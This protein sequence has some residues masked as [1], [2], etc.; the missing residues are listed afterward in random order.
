MIYMGKPSFMNLDLKTPLSNHFGL[1]SFREPQELIIRSILSKHDTMVI[2]PTGGG[3]SLCFQLPALLLPGVTIVISPLIAL[4]KDQVDGLRAQGIAAGMINSLLS[5]Q[6]QR[7]QIQLMALGKLKLVYIAPERF[8]S[9]SFIDALSRCEIS[10][11]AV[12]EAHCLSQW[13]HDFRPD[14]LRINQAL[15]YLRNPPVAAFTATATPDVRNDIVTHLCMTNP[16]IF[17]AGFARPNLALRIVQVSG[18]KEKYKRLKTLIREHK[19]G[20]IYCATRKSVERVADRLGTEG[21]P[22]TMYHGGMK[23]SERDYAQNAFIGG[24]SNVVVATNAFGMGID[25]TDIRFVAHFEMPGSVEAYYQEAG[26]AGRDGKSSVSELLFSFADKRVHDFFLEGRNPGKDLIQDVY[27]RLKTLSDERHEVVVSIDDLSSG[28]DSSVNPMAVGTALTILSRRD[29][30]QRFDVSG[31]LKRGTRLLKPHLLPEGLEFDVEAL[32]E[33]AKRDQGRLKSVID[34]A[35]AKTCR[36]SWILDYFGEGQSE[37]CR[38]C[39]RCVGTDDEVLRSPTDE[40]MLIVRKALSGVARMSYRCPGSANWRPRFGRDRILQSLIGGD[41]TYFKENG[42]ET[43]ST[44]GILK[45]E[46]K[47]YVKELLRAMERAGLLEVTAGEYPLTGLTPFGTEVMKGK[48]EFVM[49]WPHQKGSKKT[50]KKQSRPPEPSQ[51]IA[52]T[53][54]DDLYRKLNDKRASLATIRKVPP[55]VIFSNAVLEA[56]AIKKPATVEESREISGIGDK[57]AK[58]LLPTFLKIIQGHVGETL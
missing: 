25:R 21:V 57:K 27:A 20:I 36:Q 32:A 44:Y 55:Y 50:K 52:G 48:S 14:Y 35:Y 10:L 11:L 18:A 8:R 15:K 54:D 42:L 49:V 4:M 39:D 28:M 9:G 45:S 7:E 29:Y 22:L 26:R 1:E 51:S 34:F 31:T 12:D 33:K 19:I 37:Y 16:K 6:E 23:D 41:K 17:V 38:Q 3:K 40:E 30:I 46:G 43:L 56:L 47:T 5:P 58:K 53:I 13:G 24:A 2:M